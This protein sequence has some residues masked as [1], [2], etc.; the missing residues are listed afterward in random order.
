[1]TE[2]EWYRRIGE[3]L[4]QE[5]KRRGWTTYDVAAITDT[6]AVA[7]GFW[8][9]GLRRMRAYHYAVLRQEGLVP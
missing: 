9:R 8:E 6:S 5:R 4:R 2:Q 1:M 7:I 3:H